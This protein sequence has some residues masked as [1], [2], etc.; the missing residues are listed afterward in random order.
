MNIHWGVYIWTLLH[1][2]GYSYIPLESSRYDSIIRNIAHILPCPMC[3]DHYKSLIGYSDC[4]YKCGNK[5]RMIIWLNEIHNKVNRR[6]KKKIYTLDDAHKIFYSNGQLKIDHNKIISFIKIVQKY[7][8]KRHS[9]II[10][11]ISSTILVNLCHIFPCIKCREQLKI[12]AKNKTMTLDNTQQWIKNMISII[13]KDTP[14]ESTKII[15]RNSSIIKKK[16]IPTDT[17]KIIR[18]NKKN[19]KIKKKSTINN[20]LKINVKTN[21]IK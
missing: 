18:N 3:R 19:L 8:I 20:I 21:K 2:L 12:Y 17:K 5:K 14:I 16:I 11:S 6:L 15:K 10:S 13:N 7:S 9:P 1:L 4:K